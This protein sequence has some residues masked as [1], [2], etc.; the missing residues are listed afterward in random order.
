MVN[1]SPLFLF[2]IVLNPQSLAV[3]ETLTP[4]TAPP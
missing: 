4:P 3:Q 1:P 2:A